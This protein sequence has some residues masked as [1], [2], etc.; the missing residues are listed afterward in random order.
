VRL[1]TDTHALIWALA[2][3]SKLP[4][5]TADKLRDPAVL[6]YVSA[7]NTWEIAIKSALGKIDADLGEVMEGVRE[8]GFI[9][10]AVTMEH[11]HRLTELPPVHR[12]PF[13]RILVAQALDEGLT[14]VTH[15]DVLKDY[16]A[17]V[18]WA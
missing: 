11:C 6:V 1:L 18:L 9:E 3:P 4:R 14:L 5:R 17:P 16:P 15:D 7:A 13:D 10:L 12:D 8:M 2:Q